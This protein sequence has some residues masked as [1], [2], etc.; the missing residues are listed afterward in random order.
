MKENIVKRAGKD[1]IA[2]ECISARFLKVSILIKI[3]DV[4]FVV[5][6]APTKEAAKG[7]KAK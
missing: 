7:Q 1:G 5:A 2:I 4:T 3:N 6:Y